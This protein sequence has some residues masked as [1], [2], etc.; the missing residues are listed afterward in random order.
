MV[1]V[2]RGVG[3]VVDLPDVR[4]L[5]GPGAEGLELALRLAHPGAEEVELAEGLRARFR[6]AV[7]RVEASRAKLNYLIMHMRAKSYTHRL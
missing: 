3:N 2:A 1:R 4:V 5:A 7:D 6:V